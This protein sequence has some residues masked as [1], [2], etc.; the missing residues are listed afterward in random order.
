MIDDHQPGG[1]LVVVGDA[2]IDYFVRVPHIAGNDNKA[3]GSLAG[4]YGGGM[5]ANLAAA[6]ARQGIAVDLITKTGAGPDTDVALDELRRLGVSLEHSLRDLD[7][8]TWMCFV[9]LDPSGE[10]ALTGADT[11]IKLPTIEEIDASIM[12]GAEIVAP[13][14]DDLTWATAVAELA[15]DH[16]ARVAVD[17]EPDAFEPEQPQFARLIELS[18]I[19]FLN[20]SSAAKLASTGAPAAAGRLLQLGASLVIT[21]AGANGAFSLDRDGVL[22]RAR[23]RQPVIA[24]DTTGAGDAL[25]GAFL[26]ALLTGADIHDS[27]RRAVAQATRCVTAVGGRSYLSDSR[28][29]ERFEDLITITTER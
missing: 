13:L 26:G 8:P 4:V 7:H 16:G 9:Q 25:A 14:A 5:S 28:R 11:G 15:H 19:V 1:R 23:L 12:T 2:S 24:V 3:I 17:L 22:H 21:S 20:A 6:A 27:L 29:G 18:D 10:K